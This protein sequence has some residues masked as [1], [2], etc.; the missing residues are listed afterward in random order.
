MDVKKDQMKIIDTT[1]EEL[2]EQEG[3]KTHLAV[4]PNPVLPRQHDVLMLYSADRCQIGVAALIIANF[5]ISAIE[6]QIG[7]DAAP[8]V[9]SAFEW[10]FN[11]L[12]GIELLINIYANFWCVFWK[13][14]WNIFD[15]F[16]VGVSWMSLIG[17]VPGI[18]VLRLFRAFR[19]FRLFKRIESVRIIIVAVAASLPGV[20]NAFVLLI[21]VM[22]I[23]GIMGVNFFR[24]DF[25][26]LFGNFSVAMLTLFQVMTF[27]SWVSGVARPVCLFY[28][29][30]WAP[31]Y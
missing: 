12:F 9:F 1:N 2:D 22:G 30:A 10:T 25:P 16:I 8:K 15:V 21:I 6:A 26:D 29:T 24:K 5:V 19:A 4:V 11:I 3:V 14:G 17:G 27:D 13:N 7:E 18:T 28:N 31:I 20:A 23:W